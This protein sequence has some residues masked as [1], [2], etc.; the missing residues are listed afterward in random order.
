MQMTGNDFIAALKEETYASQ[1]FTA[2]DQA[3]VNLDD[4]FTYAQDM[5][6]KAQLFS[7]ELLISG[8]EPISLR[9]ESSLVNLPLRYTN[10]ISKIVINDPAADVQ[11][12][13]IIEHP[14][15]T[16]SG[17]RIEKVASVAAFVDDPESSQ[18]KI[19]TFFDKYLQVINEQVA[20]AATADEETTND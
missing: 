8:D 20:L 9:L 16:K 18:V 17:L 2:A 14:L 12:Y 4:L 1:S 15:V 13:M 7:G 10:A 11:V 5:A 19:A 6:Q 3:T